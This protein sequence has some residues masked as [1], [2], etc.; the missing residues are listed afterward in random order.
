MEVSGWW[1][2]GDVPSVFQL[3]AGTSRAPERR[4]LVNLMMR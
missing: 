4:R 3:S 2:M 1:V